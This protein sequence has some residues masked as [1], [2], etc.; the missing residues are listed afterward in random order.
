VTIRTAVTGV[1]SM[2]WNH[3]RVYNELE[4]VDLVA[5]ADVDGR[6]VERATHIYGAR[7]YTDYREMLRHEDLDVVSIAVPTQDS[8]RDGSGRFA[9][10]LSHPGGDPSLPPSRRARRWWPSLPAGDSSSLWATLNVSIPHRRT[11]AKAEA[12]RSRTGSPDPR[13]A[14]GSFPNQSAGRG[15]GD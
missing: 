5:V 3:A 11:E 12:G 8:P 13:P 7:G 1:G 9:T 4:G 15:S 14:L 10:R 6:M 2:G